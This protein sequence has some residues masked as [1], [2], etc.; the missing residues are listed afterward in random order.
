MS[1]SISSSVVNQPIEVTASQYQRTVKGNNYVSKKERNIAN[2]YRKMTRRSW[3]LLQPSRKKKDSDSVSSKHSSSGFDSTCQQSV[4][5]VTVNSGTTMKAS[6][7]HEE[8]VEQ[9]LASLLAAKDFEE[10]NTVETDSSGAKINK[11]KNRQNKPQAPWKSL[12]RLVSKG[13]H[14]KHQA[15]SITPQSSLDG[16]D[17]GHRIQRRHA[18][19]HDGG[20]T[21]SKLPLDTDYP[22]RKRH[23]SDGITSS[24]DSFDV[25]SATDPQHAMDQ[26]IRGRLDGVDVLSLGKAS[27]TMTNESSLQW[28][29]EG[30]GNDKSESDAFSFDPLHTSFCDLPLP[31][32]P[33]KIID[34]MIWA[35]AG[36]DQAEIIFEGFY[37]GC[38]DRWGV[39]IPTTL[40]SSFKTESS[41]SAKDV[42]NALL[43]NVDSDA[44][45]ATTVTDNAS[46]PMTELWESLWGVVSTPPPIPSHMNLQATNTGSTI[47]ND[48]NEDH[49]QFVDMCNV[50]IDLDDDAFM[51][52]CPQH[53]NSIHEVVMVA[54][55]ARRF[56]C[57]ISIFEKLQ[58]GLHGNYKYRH[59]AAST[60]HNIAMIQLSQGQYEEALQS[61]QK[62]AE[63]RKDCLPEEHP[64][65]AV[66]L[67]REG[68]A[69]FAL[70]SMSQALQSFEAA[71]ALYTS[72]D[73][74][75]AKILNS[76]GV[77]RYHLE[78]YSRAL[79]SF[80]AALEI[81]RPWLEGPVRRE[82]IIYVAS[83]ILSNM[84]KVHF[85]N[86]D[87]DLA[88]LVFEEACLMQTSIFRM[89]HETVLGSM[90]NMGRAQTQQ[91][92]HTEALKIFSSLYRSQTTR[93]GPENKA[94]IETLGMMGISH[95]KLLEYEE[96]EKCMT[97]VAK[98]QRNKMEVSHPLVKI[99]NERLEQI[100]RCLQGKEPLWV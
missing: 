69:H 72:M 14:N 67:Q 3:N 96:A 38:N 66:S 10:L 82:S 52:N 37:P 81:Q 5:N 84:G 21:F 78:D 44:S 23:H 58:R 88:Y 85:Q 2:S 92:N 59:L 73:P 91:G 22:M 75:R 62:S 46:L 32:P 19:S 26:V 80:T 29:Y 34:E 8:H 12:K 45:T 33:S 55:Q 70:G 24:S 7:L 98:W 93:F 47:S 41:K 17:S 13:K 76:I 9:K 16:T 25:L 79:K 50:P 36:I 94:C 11:I 40:P 95:F 87:H 51:I 57:A 61:F 100:K 77:A 64:D 65:I 18:K 43:F 42:I 68:M 74:T 89:D 28:I 99:T 63:V 56:D 35:P 20:E 1:G 4:A 30:S 86:G 71:L 54:L 27:R 49:Q 97:K 60:S 31:V 48:D 15:S 90:D 53:V 6:N 83:T 39:R